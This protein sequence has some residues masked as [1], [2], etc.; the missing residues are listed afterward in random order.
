M[1]PVAKLLAQKHVYDQ[2]S[3]DL[4][5]IFLRNSKY[6][7]LRM[8]RI[9]SGPLRASVGPRNAAAR[10]RLHRCNGSLGGGGC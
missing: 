4:Q 3:L 8:E 1:S 7:A 9:G 10:F 2:L 6:D 5:Q